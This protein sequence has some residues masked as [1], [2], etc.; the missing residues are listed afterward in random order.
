[1]Y[2]ESGNDW[3]ETT[4]VSDVTEDLAH[5]NMDATVRHSDNHIL[6]AVHSN[7]DNAFDGLRT[8]DLTVDSIASPTITAKTN[9]FTDQ[10]ESAQVALLVNQQ[11]DDVYVAYM[12][13][14][15][16][17]SAV[18][19]VYH[20][21]TDGMDNWDAESAYSEATADDIRRVSSGRTVGNDGGF[22]Q[23]AFYNDDLSDI[24]VYEVND[25]AIAAAGGGFAHSQG[26]IVG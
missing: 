2:D 5:I 25:V 16:W 22:Y 18:D 17:Q 12:K 8:W 6:L 7:D 15:T 19:V 11:N 4:V 3:T 14:G 21:S 1:M 9:I 23:P 26:V 24:F 10:G 13:G 20:K